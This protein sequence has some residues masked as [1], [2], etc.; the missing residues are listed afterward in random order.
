MKINRTIQ[1][2]QKAC[3]KREILRGDKE[4]KKKRIRPGVST[5]SE[6]RVLYCV[7]SHRKSS[8]MSK[9]TSRETI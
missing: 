4:E 5:F 9:L 6:E 7:D 1:L 2:K 3:T 8:V